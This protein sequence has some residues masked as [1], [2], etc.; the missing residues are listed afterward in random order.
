MYSVSM[1][2]RIMILVGGV[3][4]VVVVGLLHLTT[5]SAVGPLGVLALFICVYMVCV[6]ATYF[7]LVMITAL[8]RRLA[9]V[10]A[11]KTTLAVLPRLKLYYYA[12]VLGL[13]PVI[14]LGMQSVGGVRLVDMALVLLFEG[15]ALFYVQKRF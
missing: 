9:G 15:L 1:K 8:M 7:F 11:L 6:V 5:P 3:S 13:V 14:L 4:L 12:S 10:G 2:Q